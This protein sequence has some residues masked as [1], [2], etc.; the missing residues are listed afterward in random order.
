MK[1]K[2]KEC[3]SQNFY[4]KHPE[5]SKSKHIVGEDEFWG[6]F[7]SLIFPFCRD[8]LTLSIHTELGAIL[9][10]WPTRNFKMKKNYII[11]IRYINK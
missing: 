1:K 6:K 3:I 8:I 10:L 9:N 4:K 11:Y 2:A 5:E 7:C